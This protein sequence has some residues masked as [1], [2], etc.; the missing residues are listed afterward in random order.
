MIEVVGRN[1]QDRP[2][3]RLLATARWIK[4]GEPDFA[5]RG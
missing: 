3:A 2:F 4:I 5:A 1:D